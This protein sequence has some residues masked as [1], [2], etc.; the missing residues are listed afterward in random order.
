MR[1]A[2]AGIGARSGK[3]RG[4]QRFQ[5]ARGLGHQQADLPVAGVKAERDG[6][7]IFRAQAAV[8]AQDQKLGIEK[9]IRVPAHSGVL[10]EAE[11]IA[12]GLGEQ[13]LGRKRQRSGRAGRMRVHAKQADVICFQ[14]GA[15]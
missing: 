2:I 10:R 7:A 15:E 5:L 3:R 14:Y 11:K 12:G 13:H 6:L 9:A 1:A 8:R 4:A